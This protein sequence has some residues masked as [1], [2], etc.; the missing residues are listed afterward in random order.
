MLATDSLSYAAQRD[1]GGIQKLALSEP[2]P[3][4][5]SHSQPAQH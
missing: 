2:L 1:S 4:L 3:I 5:L